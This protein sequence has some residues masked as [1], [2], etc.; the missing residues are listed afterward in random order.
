VEKLEKLFDRLYTDTF[1]IVRETVADMREH[2]WSNNSSLT[3]EIERAKHKKLDELSDDLVGKIESIVTF[4]DGQTSRLNEVER[5]VSEAVHKSDEIS[6]GFRRSLLEDQVV[7]TIQQHGKM[8][9][10]AWGIVAG[11]FFGILQEQFSLSEII[12]E[13]DRYR[14]R[15]ELDWNLLDK[16][17]AVPIPEDNEHIEYYKRVT[18]ISNKAVIREKHAWEKLRGEGS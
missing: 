8:I 2:V 7:I 1:S 9:D 11:D 3:S 13:L 4:Q 14:Q 15:G 16:K 12:E 10:G 6:S 18:S 5:L 17:G